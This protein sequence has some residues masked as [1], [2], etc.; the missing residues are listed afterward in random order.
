MIFRINTTT[1]FFQNVS[2]YRVGLSSRHKP[3]AFEH[4]THMP[5]MRNV[6]NLS[7]ACHSYLRVVNNLP[8]FPGQRVT[9]E[10]A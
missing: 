6:L 2:F 4:N 5:Q 8:L 3:H 10:M 9:V 7:H 1:H